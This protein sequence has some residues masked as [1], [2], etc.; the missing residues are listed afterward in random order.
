MK[1]EA[2]QKDGAANKIINTTLKM[3]TAEK[4]VYNIITIPMSLY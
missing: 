3:L 1:K 4:I 2:M